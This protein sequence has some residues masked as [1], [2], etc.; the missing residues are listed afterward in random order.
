[1][2]DLKAKSDW[3]WTTLKSGSYYDGTKV[4]IQ[5]YLNVY[6]NSYMGELTHLIV[7]YDNLQ[8]KECFS[9]NPPTSTH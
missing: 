8:N 2:L 1:M 3:E 4:G 7:N 5:L 6:H 9:M